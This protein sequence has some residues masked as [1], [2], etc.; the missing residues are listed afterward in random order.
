MGKY[1][2]PIAGVLAW[3]VGLAALSGFDAMDG[4]RDGKVTEAEMDAAQ[5]EI[6]GKPASGGGLAS[7]EKIKEFEAGHA[8]LSKQ[9]R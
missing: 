5:Q 3:S 8:V 1:L 9:E 7:A 2:L 4:H 6:I